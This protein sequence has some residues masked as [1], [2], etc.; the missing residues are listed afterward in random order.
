MR[1][2]VPLV[3]IVAL[4]VAGLVA[5]CSGDATLPVGP[6]DGQ[7]EAAASGGAGG[8]HAPSPPLPPCV[9]PGPVVPLDAEFPSE[10]PLPPGTVVTSSGKTAAGA[11]YAEGYAPIGIDNGIDFFR[12]QLPRAGFTLVLWENDVT[13]ADGA[14]RGHGLTGTWIIVPAPDC[15]DVGYVSVGT[16]PES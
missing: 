10:F 13:E 8:S 14:F 15:P 1:V 5:G 4:G 12:E 2:R 6:T 9:T 7:A 3:V 16:Y 11:A